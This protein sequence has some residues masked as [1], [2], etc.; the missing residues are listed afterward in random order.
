VSQSTRE[1]GLRLA[2]GATAA[3]LRRLVLR[4]G[5]AL[6]AAGVAVGVAAAIQL[7]RLLGNLLYQVSPRDVTVFSV[8][9]VVMAM[10]SITACLVPAWR[11]TRTDPLLALRG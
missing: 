9:F 7:T 3:D 8:A 1:F 4:R 6:S 5:L 10:A 11:A 2:L